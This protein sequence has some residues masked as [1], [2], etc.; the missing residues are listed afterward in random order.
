[1]EWRRENWRGK[2]KGCGEEDERTEEGVEEKGEEE[3]EGLL[4]WDQLNCLLFPLALA[5]WLLAIF[6]II[7]FYLCNS[8]PQVIKE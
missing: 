4:Q 8:Q 6:L 3:Q 1:M 2:G 7:I 5:L